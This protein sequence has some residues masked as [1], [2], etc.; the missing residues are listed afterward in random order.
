MSAS[1]DNFCCDPSPGPAPNC[2]ASCPENS[3]CDS[4]TAPSCVCSPGYIGSP[5]ECS[6]S[7][8]PVVGSCVAPDQTGYG[9]HWW[10]G[11][12]GISSPNI[13]LNVGESKEF[14]CKERSG[15]LNSISIWKLKPD[16]VTYRCDSS[17]S[18]PEYIY[19]GNPSTDETPCDQFDWI[20]VPL[21]ILII[22]IFIYALYLMGAFPGQKW[23]W[24]RS[25]F[26]DAS[27]RN[28]PFSDLGGA[29]VA[30]TAETAPGQPASFHGA[31]PLHPRVR[32]NQPQASRLESFARLG[33]E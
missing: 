12:E 1:P 7:M 29:T 27:G 32:G 28:I 17:G 2:P 6:P 22:L 9:K 15:F 31:R 18:P 26:R 3:Y 13:S 24:D 11:T 10:T 30:A 8:P 21:K 4:S 16:P 5:P 33:P 23:I 14:N 19:D 25:P 20:L